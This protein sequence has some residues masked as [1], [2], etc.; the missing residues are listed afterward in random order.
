MNILEMVQNGVVEVSMLGDVPNSRLTRRAE[1]LVK[2]R[3]ADALVEGLLTA[4]L[5]VACAVAAVV[6]TLLVACVCCL[7]V[8]AT[9]TIALLTSSVVPE[10]VMVKILAFV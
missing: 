2:W 7:N 1:M 5:T 6:E 8:R 3:L 9:Q 4:M 10:R